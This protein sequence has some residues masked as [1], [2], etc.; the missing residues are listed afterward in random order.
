MFAAQQAS[1]ILAGCRFPG[2]VKRRLEG[3]CEKKEKPKEMAQAACDVSRVARASLACAGPR[4]RAAQLQS[5]AKPRNRA[6]ASGGLGR[7]AHHIGRNAHHKTKT[8]CRRVVAHAAS[9]FGFGG[10]AANFERGGRDAAA[11]AGKLAP[12]DVRTAVGT[13][14]EA[15]MK[16]DPV[17]FQRALTDRVSAHSP[18]TLRQPP[19]ATSERTS[20]P[21]R[22]HKI[23]GPIA[24]KKKKKGNRA[25][26]EGGGGDLCGGCLP[27]PE[28]PQG[29]RG[30]A[31]SLSPARARSLGRATI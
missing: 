14:L 20:Y 17:A 4:S 28:G 29:Y 11:R 19:D 27:C 12:L 13:E 6:V 25:G 8:G 21:P 16:T 3:T 2:G 15:I 7:N 18:P 31:T 26:G 30:T 5:A 1:R 24:A 9:S 23:L 10:G 22:I